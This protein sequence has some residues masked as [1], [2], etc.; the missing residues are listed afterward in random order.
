MT[1][2]LVTTAYVF[3]SIVGV[4]AVVLTVL[5]YRDMRDERRALIKLAEIQAAVAGRTTETGAAVADVVD[6]VRA[7]GESQ[8]FDRHA[9]DAVR[10]IVGDQR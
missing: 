3:W 1:D 2:T 4:I 7:D 9:E 8:A 5:A 10:L 6:L